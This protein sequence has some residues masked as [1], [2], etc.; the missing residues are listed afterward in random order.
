MCT[1]ATTNELEIAD[2]RQHVAYGWQ[3]ANDAGVVDLDD[4]GLRVLAP[5]MSPRYAAEVERCQGA[6]TPTGTP[7][8]HEG[9][10]GGF[11]RCVVEGVS[12][13]ARPPAVHVHRRLPARAW[14]LRGAGAPRAGDHARAVLHCAAVSP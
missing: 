9:H 12:S 10:V 11:R 1:S 6:L 13:R 7:G 8:V 2:V 5:R 14:R 3:Y 4:I